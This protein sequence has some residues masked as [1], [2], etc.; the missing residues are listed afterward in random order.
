MPSKPEFRPDIEGLRA[1]AIL[2]VLLYHAH[3]SW[4][5][6]GFVGVDVFFVLSGFLITRSLLYETETTGS[7]RL[8]EFYARRVRRLL[9]ASALVLVST[10][11]GVL[12]SLPS[13]MWRTFGGDVA[14][15]GAYVV[16]W[17]FAFR[18]VDYLAQDVLPSPVQHYWSLSVEEQFYFLWPALIITGIFLARRLGTRPRSVI[19]LVLVVAVLVPSLSWSILSSAREPASAFFVTT[20]R[21]WELAAGALV[22][23]V[24][25]VTFRYGSI[26]VLTK[27]VGLVLVVGA[28]ML[29]DA[30]VAWPGVAAL[31]PIIG[32]ALLVIGGGQGNDPI[33]R[34]L[35]TA[36]MKKVGAWSY[37][38]YLWHWPPLAIL[39]ARWGGLSTAEAVLITLAS[40]VPA[41]AAYTWVETPL[42]FRP[43]LKSSPSL[44]MSLGSSLTLISIVAGL[45]MVISV[46]M[47]RPVVDSAEPSIAKGA[48]AITPNADAKSLLEEAETA[49]SLVPSP[50]TATSDRPDL[51]DEGC[52]VSQGDAEPVICERGDPAGGSLVMVVGD[53]KIAQWMPA[54][55]TIGKRQG[56]KIL[57]ATKSACEFTTAIPSISSGP[58]SSCKEWNSRV[59]ELVDEMRPD[60]IVVSQGSKTAWNAST[61]SEDRD[62]MIQGMLGA[63]GRATSAGAQIVVFLDNPHPGFVVRDCVAE[64]PDNLDACTVPLSEIADNSARS[65]QRE[66]AEL[67]G[68]PTLD[69]IDLICPDGVCLPV[70]GGVLVY[71]DGSHIT[72][73]YV[74]SMIDVIEQRLLAAA[75]RAMGS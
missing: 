24:G 46:S 5:P 37:S 58:Y 30:S 10:G 13:S 55:D 71:R 16:N 63:Y 15:A 51:Y 73:T 61:G 17:R 20:T 23:V 32:T 39:G 21:L 59:F 3:I 14:A 4:F 8:S 44:T 57:A 70:V 9:P 66:V 7:I 49:G 25:T 34:G 60:L 18:A 38:L 68:Y 74:N 75:G 35:S 29:V 47:S 72:V 54:L 19:G 6:G 48:L 28:A 40:F 22:A 11:I 50:A 26:R 2:L 52:Q 53:S 33:E 64:N 36:L 69:V 56:W 42:R 65:V 43:S 31:A 41:V 45:A 62:M 67:G 27:V 1:L 12:V